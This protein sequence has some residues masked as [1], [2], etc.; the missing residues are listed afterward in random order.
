MLAL[1]FANAAALPLTGSS[2]AS[3]TAS[4]P[5]P[6]PDPATA[7]AATGSG[8]TYS[9]VSATVPAECE[10]RELKVTL[11]NGTTELRSG[12]ATVAGS[13]ATTVDLG[14]SY[15]AAAN[16]TVR[17]VVDGWDLPTTWSFTPPAPTGPVTPGTTTTDLRSVQWTSV[18]VGRQF[19]VAVTV[20][21]T[22]PNGEEDWAVDLNTDQR[23]FNGATTGYQITGTD[24]ANVAF[25]SEAPV[26]GKFT[27]VG[28]GAYKKLRAVDSLSFTV[29]NYDTPPP[30]YDPGLAYAVVSSPPTGDWNPCVTSTVSVVGTP[31]F[32][33]GW[34][35]DVDMSPAI[36]AI[37]AAGGVFTGMHLP[38]GD[39][40]MSQISETVWRVTGTGWNTAGVRDST[41][42][43][44]TLCARRG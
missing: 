43:T 27:I 32:F 8:T 38:T 10:G 42:Q 6:D 34:R 33:A 13:G 39:M 23:P 14:G 28:T 7:T 30:T 37:T 20:S 19:C 16:L 31:V 21:T 29:C 40:T 4:H 2:L 24:W 9:A 22:N 26:G 12:T 5:C 44:F 3:R 41:T 18:T 1:T 15:T 25:A 11:L 17:A 36:S 35:A